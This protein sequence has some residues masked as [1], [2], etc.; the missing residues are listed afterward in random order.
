M[1]K[2]GGVHCKQVDL[3][4]GAEG[5][6]ARPSAMGDWNMQEKQKR[7]SGHGVCVICGRRE[8]GRGV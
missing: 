5:G 6:G 3:D 4:R 2:G 7:A 8:D 1:N